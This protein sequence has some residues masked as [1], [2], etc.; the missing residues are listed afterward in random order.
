M[1]LQAV[2]ALVLSG[3]VTVGSDLFDAF[4]DIDV[5]RVRAFAKTMPGTTADTMAALLL[6]LMFGQRIARKAA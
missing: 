3:W 4:D 1:H 2:S 6:G 5:G